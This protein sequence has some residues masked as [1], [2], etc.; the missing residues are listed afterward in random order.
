VQKYAAEPGPYQEKAKDIYKE[1]RRNV[2]DNVVKV[3][4]RYLEL[5]RPFLTIIAGVRTHRIRLGAI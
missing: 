5:V 4:L 1:L 3:G 2:V